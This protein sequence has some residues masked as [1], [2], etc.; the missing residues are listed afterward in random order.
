MTHFPPSFVWG[1]AAASY[2]IEGAAYEDGKGLSIWDMLCRK[3]GAIWEGH[4]GDLACD[5]YHRCAE[6][7]ALMR[8]LGLQAYR[9]SISWPRVLPEGTGKVNPSGLG[10]YD[11]LVD[12]L[13]EAGVAPYATLFHWDFPYAL[14]C[15]GGWL[16]RDSADW[17]ANYARVVVE[18]LGDRVRDWMTL[19]EIQVFVGMG[20]L[21]GEHAPG[22]KL[23]MPEVLRV[24]HHALLAHGK[25]VQAIRAASPGPCRVGWAP[26]IFPLIP[27][28][29]SPEDVAAA[30][31]A[32]F[33]VPEGDYA[34]WSSS[35]WLD[36]VFFGRYPEDGLRVFASAAPPVESGDMETI[37]EPLDFCGF[38]IY[39]GRRVQAGPE[40]YPVV[41]PHATGYAKTSYDWAVMPE[42]LY[43][44]PRFMYE[45]YGVPLFIT[46]NGLANADWISLDGAVHDPQRIDFT[47]RYLLA[48][49]RAIADGV[50]VRGYFHWSLMDNFEWAQ[51]Y[52]E[53]FGL[54]FVDY[55]TQQRVL[56][57]SATWYRDVIASNGVKLHEG[58]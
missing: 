6:D 11:R 12:S 49:E 41:V 16:N 35:W 7:V 1:A 23:G 48:L 50:D 31:L 51:G 34:L 56:K 10:F 21:D 47:R 27:M 20:H 8:Q 25:A 5:H 40:G 52:R 14:Y 57:D 37:A 54:I 17:F 24:G 43:W 44:G 53:R 39:Q 18:A 33:S 29:K 42:T 19:N 15:K 13:L 32:M 46:E 26:T 36:P 3:P 22:D 2:Q 58:L 28:T 55:A 45:R 9:F 30:R 4:T 38:N